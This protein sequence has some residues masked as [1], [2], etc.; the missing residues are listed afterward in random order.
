VPVVR[1]PLLAWGGLLRCLLLLWAVRRG[2]ARPEFRQVGVVAVLGL[3]GRGARPA[4]L[5]GGFRGGGGGAVVVEDG[6]ASGMDLGRRGGGGGLEL[7]GGDGEGGGGGGVGALGFDFGVLLLHLGFGDEVLLDL[8]DCGGGWVSLAGVLGSGRTGGIGVP[9]RRQGP[10]GRFS[11]PTRN[12]CLGFLALSP[13]SPSVAS[14]RVRFDDMLGGLVV[15]GDE[16]MWGM[17]CS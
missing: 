14:S 4:R 16:G 8:G 13:P 1:Q 15:V 6:L 11:G 7:V 5:A 9:F 3:F 2:H 17:D 10:S 12:P